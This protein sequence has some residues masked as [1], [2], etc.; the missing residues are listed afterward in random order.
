MAFS[1]SKLSLEMNPETPSAPKSRFFLDALQ[2]HG[3]VRGCCM[4]SLCASNLLLQKSGV[5][6]SATA[7]PGASR[8]TRHAVLLNW[9]K[10]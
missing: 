2:D 8:S 6:S 1:V 4:C 10:S 9:R 5:G 3:P 7:G